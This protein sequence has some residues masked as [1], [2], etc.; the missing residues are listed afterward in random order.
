MDIDGVPVAVASKLDLIRPLINK[1][2]PGL[3]PLISLTGL[4]N[5]SGSHMMHDSIKARSETL[6][7]LQ[8]LGGQGHIVGKRTA[9]VESLICIRSPSIVLPVIM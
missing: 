3:G 2:L 1:M 6:G 5:T 8:L 7:L 4:H 9:A